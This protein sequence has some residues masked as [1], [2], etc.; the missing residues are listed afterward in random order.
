M[1]FIDKLLLICGYRDCGRILGTIET[2]AQIVGLGN[3]P[4]E[5]KYI[6]AMCEEHWEEQ[7]KLGG[8]PINE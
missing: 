6:I 2:P 4:F 1:R 5:D 3:T 7:H 8:G